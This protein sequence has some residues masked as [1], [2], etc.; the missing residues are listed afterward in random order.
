[1]N[2]KYLYHKYKYKYLKLKGGSQSEPT[3]Y[4]D[5]RNKDIEDIEKEEIVDILEEDIT[6]ESISDARTDETE[7]TE[8]GTVRKTLG[9]SAKSYNIEQDQFI[10][11]SDNPDKSKILSIDTLDDFDEFTDKYGSVT[12][13]NLIYIKWDNVANKYNG[14]YVN[15]GLSDERYST[16]YFKGKTYKSW[17]ES[18]FPY[19]DVLIFLP[20]PDQI[21]TGEVIKEPFKGI[22]FDENNFSDDQY[23]AK[24]TKSPDYVK[25]KILL[26]NS[27]DI[28]DEFTNKYGNLFETQKSQTRYIRINW[29]L[30]KTDYRGFYLDKDSD[31]SDR[32]GMA[33]YRGDKY[34]SWVK[35]DKIQHGKVYIFS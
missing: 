10:S 22:I 32:Y 11:L 13:N 21:V 35:V 12:D 34:V 15:S 25:N 33:F 2:Y 31:I 8:V 29:D 4:D 16:A 24:F 28:F 30:A 27:Y 19:D 20:V 9:K 6:L 3:L 5:V 1:M 23:I 17:W 18:E 7:S 26:I 14:I